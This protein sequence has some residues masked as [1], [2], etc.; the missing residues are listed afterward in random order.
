MLTGL[1]HRYYSLSY[2]A[3]GRSS[4]AASRPANTLS[5]NTSK[6][7]AYTIQSMRRLGDRFKFAERKMH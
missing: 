2:R 7:S 5:I 6:T 3:R 4:K 1:L